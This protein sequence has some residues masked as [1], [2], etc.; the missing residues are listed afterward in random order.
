VYDAECY[1]ISEATRMAAVRSDSEE[2]EEVTVFSDST[3]AIKRV[4]HMGPGQ[5][6]IIAIKPI[7]HNNKRVAK[8]I[9]VV[10]RWLPSHE[11]VDEIEKADKEVK[12]AALGQEKRIKAMAER[13][14]GMSLARILREV[15]EAKWM[16]TEAWWKA[17]FNKKAVYRMNK[18][19][20]MPVEVSL[21]KKSITSRCL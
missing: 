17:K 1:A 15:T 21:V 12:A 14:R 18:K 7:E 9:P 16:E 4:Q 19:R 6:Q 5:G 10:F 3:T 8:G 11:A 13:Y 20:K 2:L